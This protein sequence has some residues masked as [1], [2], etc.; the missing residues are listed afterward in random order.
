MNASEKPVSQ[1]SGISEYPDVDVCIPVRNRAK[2]LPRVLDAL[3]NL[4]YPKNKIR[5]IFVDDESTD[6]TPNILKNF[7]ERHHSEY[8]EILIERV[9][10][11]GFNIPRVRNLAF[12]HTKSSLIFWLDSDVLPPSDALKIL[13]ADLREDDSVVL[14]CIPYAYREED[15][16][17]SSLPI[18]ID[19]SLGCTLIRRDLLE[20]IGGF[21]E[22]YTRTDDLWLQQMIKKLGFKIKIHRDKRCLH[23]HTIKYH[24][25]IASK[26]V[27][28]SRSLF[29]LLIDGLWDRSL[30]RRYAYYSAILFSLM[31]LPL[32]PA[33]GLIF[34]LLLIIG[35]IWHKSV[36]RYIH[37]API[38]LVIT[39]G[40]FLT[41][42][43][44]LAWRLA[45][46]R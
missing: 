1:S 40:I 29:L 4:D 34:V 42:L 39:L 24:E 22:R 21:D 32:C 25:V 9:K 13:V 16:W 35:V 23:L 36:N 41:F 31:F 8:K 15:L 3:Y 7:Y 44:P 10:H 6:E 17:K 14:S 5:L 33:L 11:L 38:G 2:V 12:R 26:F 43:N 18:D 30:Y 19:L 45:R 46:K 28:Q 37:V 27:H 20:K